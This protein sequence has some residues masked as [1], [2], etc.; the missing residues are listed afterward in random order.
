MAKFTNFYFSALALLSGVLGLGAI[1]ASSSMLSELGLADD[2]T[3]VTVYQ[4]FGITILPFAVLFWHLKGH[5]ARAT[6]VVLAS[7]A[8]MLYGGLGLATF[9]GMQSQVLTG[10]TVPLAVESVVTLLGVVVLITTLR[11][12]AGEGVGAPPR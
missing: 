1:V 6:R 10:A 12:E 4:R 3:V 5:E 8:L 7:V 9:L 2:P 11:S